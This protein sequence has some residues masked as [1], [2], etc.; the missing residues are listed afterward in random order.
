MVFNKLEIE[1]AKVVVGW[2]IKA[3][4]MAAV[5]QSVS[6]MVLQQYVGR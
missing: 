3:G 5:G 1:C 6:P 4:G 2:F